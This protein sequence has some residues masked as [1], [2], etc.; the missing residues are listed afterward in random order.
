MIILE[1]ANLI[2]AAKL[3]TQKK[4]ITQKKKYRPLLPIIILPTIL[5][6]I[7]RDIHFIIKKV[8]I[9]TKII[10][11]TIT[12]ITII[13]I[14]TT[15]ATKNSQHKITKKTLKKEKEHNR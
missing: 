6:N 11:T 5:L 12:I 9:I 3:N 8:I 15:N 10:I 14:V 4:F 1:K 13:R 2:N 7:H